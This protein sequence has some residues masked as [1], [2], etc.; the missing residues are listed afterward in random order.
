MA[1]REGQ[2]LG[3]Y[4]LV[5]LIGR[6]A[7]A[8]VYLA[9]HV[10]LNTKVAIKILQTRVAENELEA[11]LKEA[12]TIASLVHPHIVRV[13]DFGVASDTPFLVMDFALNGT[14]RQRHPKGTQL[15]LN[16]IV[17]YVK[18]VAEALQYAHDE[19]FIH[20]DIKPENMLLGRR[21]EVLL[22]DF[23]IADIAQSS[24]S[25]GTREVAGTVAY[26]APEQIQGKPRPASDQYALGIVVYEWLSGDCPFQGSFTELCAQHIFAPPPSLHEKMP[27]ISPY[28]E[29]VVMT[30]LAKDPRQRFKSI[31]AFANALEQ[32]SRP[33]EPVADRAPQ[34]GLSSSPFEQPTGS[35][36]FALLQTAEPSPPPSTQSEGISTSPAENSP[37]P[38]IAP[39]GDEEQGAV[40]VEPETE[41]PGKRRLV[42]WNSNAWLRWG[43]GLQPAIALILGVIFY[44]IPNY[45]IDLLYK[46]NGAFTNTGPTIFNE[47]ID[48]GFFFIGLALIVP[49][50]FGAISGPWVGLLIILLGTYFGDRFADYSVSAY[51]GLSWTWYAGHIL[52]G[53]TAGLAIF[54]TLGR[55]NTGRAIIIV[56][57]TSAAAII[58][59]SAFFAYTFVLGSGGT[60]DE[61]WSGFIKLSLSS[62]IDLLLLPILLVIYNAIA[63]R[64]LPSLPSLEP[65][66]EKGSRS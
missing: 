53:F 63:S 43:I 3:N 38:D 30:A 35:P 8:D 13:T 58:I 62:A 47:N 1:D 17:P 50:F 56:V 14:L 33:E 2:Q 26:M 57:A 45:F 10:Y 7:F 29:Q 32:A 15:P 9:E 31:Q 42:S 12:R 22:S 27:A 49:L 37:L 5:R 54:T 21:N 61:V 65:E 25:Q 36:S 52:I 48:T 24:R 39:R 23:G 55:Y 44:A 6:G 40:A 64:I 16:N 11:F 46:Y 34:P 51:Y 20:R 59:G 60:S 41:T 66:E 18:Q 19:K 4:R 28:V